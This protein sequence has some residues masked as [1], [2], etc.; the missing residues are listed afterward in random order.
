MTK[1]LLSFARYSIGDMGRKSSFVHS[2]LTLFSA[3]TVLL[4]PVSSLGTPA[5]CIEFDIK[6][7]LGHPA[8]SG[9]AKALEFHDPDSRYFELGTGEGGGTVYRVLPPDGKPAYVLKEYRDPRKRDADEVTYSFLKRLPLPRDGVE[10]VY[11]EVIGKKSMRFP[12]IEGQTLKSAIEGSELAPA[13]K[14]HMIERWNRF[15][16]ETSASVMREAGIKDDGLGHYYHLRA[17]EVKFRRGGKVI[18]IW[19][20]ADNVIVQSKTG[21]M[22]IIDPY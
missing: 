12:N 15:L 19:L 22:F 9:D 6:A 5:E 4:G 18:G 16:E 13:E 21:R 20:K 8:Y 7:Y 11:P 1:A 14:E 2:I 10:I 3:L 17:Y